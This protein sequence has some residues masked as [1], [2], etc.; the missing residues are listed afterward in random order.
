[1]PAWMAE[2]WSKAQAASLR[3]LKKQTWSKKLAGE[4]HRGAERSSLQWLP[5]EADNLRKG[6]VLLLDKTG[7]ITLGNRQ[8]S[9]FVPAPGVGA[10]ELASAA[11][12][13]ST[14]DE[15]PEGRSIVVLASQSGITTDLAAET[16]EAQF[17]PFT[18]QTRFGC[19]CLDLA[20][21]TVERSGELLH[22]T[23]IKYKLLTQLPLPTRPS[24]PRHL[25]TESGIG[26]R[27]VV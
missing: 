17:V 5:M 4:Y 12:L 23:P 8:A 15:T 13:A 3:G 18:A 7:T 6:D 25:I 2:G 10:Q 26:Y 22:L 20:R 9:A 16:K 14:A 24:Q 27:F 19:F 1:M 21:H 11:R